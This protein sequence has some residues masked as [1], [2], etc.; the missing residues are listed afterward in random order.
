MRPAC[1]PYDRAACGR[2]CDGA[3][4]DADGGEAAAEATDSHRPGEATDAGGAVQ[5]NRLAAPG[6]DSRQALIG[7]IVSSGEKHY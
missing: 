2:R 5:W 1:C 7:V 3:C 6:D 4:G